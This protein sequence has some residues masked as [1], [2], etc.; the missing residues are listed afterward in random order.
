MTI[1]DINLESSKLEKETLLE[2]LAKSNLR[3]NMALEANLKID[4]IV[5]KNV[6]PEI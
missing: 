3:T 5:F 4:H 2:I 1:N 6:F